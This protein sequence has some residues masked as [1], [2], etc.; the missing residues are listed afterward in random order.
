MQ[1]L[2]EE[3]IKYPSGALYCFQSGYRSYRT[4]RELGTHLHLTFLSNP[5]LSSFFFFIA[6][7]PSV[8]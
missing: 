8:E 4:I 1:P 7:E 5:A 6:L 3:G 2:E